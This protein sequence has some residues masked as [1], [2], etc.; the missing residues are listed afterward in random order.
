MTVYE[1]K[2][3]YIKGLTMRVHDFDKKTDEMVITIKKNPSTQMN[4]APKN[5]HY[6]PAEHAVLIH[7]VTN[8]MN[9]I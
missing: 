8:S 7:N 1:N 4:T 5:L 3:Y 2:V 9:L 6:N